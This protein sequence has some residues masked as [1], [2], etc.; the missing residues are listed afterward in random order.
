MTKTN[1]TKLEYLAV[2]DLIPYARNS[3]THSE[4]Q[5]SQIAGSIREFGFTNPVLIDKDGTIV[6]GHGRVM[7][8]RKLEMDKVPCIRLGHLTPAQIRAYVIADNKLALN[9]GWD[10]QMLKSEIESI[11]E[12]GIDLGLTGFSDAEIASLFLEIQTGETDPEK[13][14]DG[15]PEYEAEEPCYRKIVVNFDTEEDVA[16]FF[17]A[18]R[19]SFTQKT[20]SIWFPEKERRSLK[21]QEWAAD[22]AEIL[23]E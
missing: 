1:Q 14:W 8:A 15:M 9:A 17:A 23:N 12:D 11:R 21:D 20:K 10:E 3:R 2:V 18:I 19:Q 13:E 7:A 22:N 6:A 16:R 5:V 4:E